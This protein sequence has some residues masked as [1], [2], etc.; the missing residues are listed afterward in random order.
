MRYQI[1]EQFLTLSGALDALPTGLEQ[2]FNSEINVNFS[3]QKKAIF[4]LP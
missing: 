4:Y 2:I 1:L 3:Q